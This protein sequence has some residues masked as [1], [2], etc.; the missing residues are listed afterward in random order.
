MEDLVLLRVPL[1]QVEENYIIVLQ[2]AEIVLLGIVKIHFLV[3]EQPDP[4][5]FHLSCQVLY[6]VPF[7]DEVGDV[8]KVVV[9]EPLDLQIIRELVYVAEIQLV[10]VE[11]LI[12]PLGPEILLHFILELI[13]KIV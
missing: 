6:D 3:K 9:D 5:Q 12:D 7:L 1:P 2:L 8:V 11:Y 13:F 10:G 4:F